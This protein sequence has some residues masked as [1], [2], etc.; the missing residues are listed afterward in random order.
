[1]QVSTYYKSTTDNV[2]GWQAYPATQRAPFICEVCAAAVAAHHRPGLLVV[3]C[4][5]GGA[6]HS[7]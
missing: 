6:G 2:Y 3:C 7:N 4:I 1:M 5:A